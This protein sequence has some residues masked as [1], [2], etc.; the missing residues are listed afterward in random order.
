[1]SINKN[2]PITSREKY[3]AKIAGEEV[4]ASNP[5]NREDYFLNEIAENEGSS[6]SGGGS[7]PLVVTLSTDLVNQATTM[8]KTWNEIHSAFPNVYIDESNN[9]YPIGG[10]FVH[11]DGVDSAYCVVMNHCSYDG[12]DTTLFIADS[13]NGYPSFSFVP[14]DPGPDV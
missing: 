4:S 1:M 11:T 2:I 7:E 14:I 10:V 6:S 13:E 12:V 3:L 9:Y 8:N 5:I